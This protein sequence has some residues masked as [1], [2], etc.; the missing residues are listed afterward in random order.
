MAATQVIKVAV[1]DGNVDYRWEE[2]ER[3]KMGKGEREK[4]GSDT[5][6]VEAICRYLCKVVK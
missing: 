4:G 3:N 5:L 6:W 1:D 2:R